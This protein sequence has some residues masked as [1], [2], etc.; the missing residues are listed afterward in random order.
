NEAKNE[1]AGQLARTKGKAKK[2]Q[3]PRCKKVYHAYCMG[4]NVADDELSSCPRHACVDC[5]DV[6]TYFCR[7]CPASLCGEHFRTDPSG[8]VA[9]TYDSL[10]HRVRRPFPRT[11]GGGFGPTKARGGGA[12]G[13]AGYGRGSSRGKGGGRGSKNRGRGRGGGKKPTGGEPAV[14]T[15]AQRRP[16]RGQVAA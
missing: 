4:F 7:F 8:I 14:E 13:L 11:R 2:A 15:I 9:E 10:Q 6:A 16:K 3:Q 5:A 1:K 12:A